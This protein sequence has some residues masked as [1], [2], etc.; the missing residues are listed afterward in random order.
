M[1]VRDMI[2]LQVWPRRVLVKKA[3]RV[4]LLPAKWGVG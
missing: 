3:E 1:R 4:I 2:Y